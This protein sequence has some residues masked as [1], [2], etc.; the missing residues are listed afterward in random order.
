MKRRLLALLLVLAMVLAMAPV[1]VLAEETDTDGA[2]DS[3][4]S[5]TY[6]N[7]TARVDFCA[8][9]DVEGY[10]SQW[11]RRGVTELTVVAASY[12]YQQM[13]DSAY[14]KIPMEDVE[15]GR[16]TAQLQLQNTFDQSNWIRV[17]LLD[18][19]LQLVCRNDTM[20]QWEQ[21]L[22]GLDGEITWSLSSGTLALSGLFNLLSDMTPGYHEWDKYSS[23]IERVVTE[24][25]RNISDSAFQGYSSLYSV[26][27]GDGLET[28]GAYAFADD[29]AIVSVTLPASVK[30]VGDYAF[31]GISDWAW[32]EFAEGFDWDN[33]TIGPGNTAIEAWKPIPEPTEGTE[34]AESTDEA[35]LDAPEETV[36]ET[37][38]ETVPEAEET[39]PETLPAAEEP[40]EEADYSGYYIAPEGAELKDEAALE[41]MAAYYGADKNSSGVHTA[42]FTGLVPLQAYLF[43]ASRTPGSLEKEDLQYIGF[44]ASDDEGNVS[45]RYIPKENVSF[46]VQ[47][48]GPEALTLEVNQDYV[49]LHPGE[50]FTFTFASNYDV[51]VWG[52][53]ENESF[54]FR[55]NEDGSW[56]LTAGEDTELAECAT[57][58]L[59]FHANNGLQTVRTR[60]RV[61]LVPAKT[62]VAGVILGETKLTRNLYDSAATQI[63]ILLDRDYPVT[64]NGTN[65]I[66]AFSAEENV[67]EGRLIRSVRFSDAA[68]P[69]AKD[70]FQI[71]VQDDRTLLLDTA[72]NLDLTDAA[73]VKAV[74]GSYK[75]GF[76][77]TFADGTELDTGVLTLTVQKKLP[78][79]KAA[80]VTLNP[81]YNATQL[82][83]VTGGSVEGLTEVVTP[84]EGVEAEV[85]V[86]GDV[87]VCL[88]ETPAK[89][90]SKSLVVQAMVEGC[91][92][93]VKL[94]IPV[95]LDVK[96]PACKLQTTNWTITRNEN[97]SIW[98]PI[99][100]T[101]KNANPGDMDFGIPTVYDAKG[102]PSTAYTAFL[103]E[104]SRLNIGTFYGDIRPAGK[105]TLTIVVPVT[106]KDAEPD[107]LVTAP[108]TFKVTVTNQDLELKLAKSSVTLNAI[109][110]DNVEAIVGMN[111]TLG[112]EPV[113]L[114]GLSFRYGIGSSNEEFS[115]DLLSFFNVQIYSEGAVGLQLNLSYL[116]SEESG[117][118]GRMDEVLA[119]TYDFVIDVVGDES[120]ID[121]WAK[122]TVHLGQDPT[123]LTGLK[124]TGAIDQIDNESFVTLSATYRNS[125]GNRVPGI[126]VTN[127]KGEDCTQLFTWRYD[128][129]SDTIHLSVNP[130]ENTPEAGK[131][132]VTLTN[133]SLGVTTSKSA[134]F[135]VKASKPAVKV[136]GKVDSLQSDVYAILS[137]NYRQLTVDGVLIW[138]DVTLYTT[139]KTP[140]PVDPSLYQVFDDEAT[141]NLKISANP[142]GESLLPAGKYTAELDYRDGT[143]LSAPVTVTQTAA[144]FKLSKSSTTVHP[145]FSSDSAWIT[146]S[147]TNV[148]AF[149]GNSG[150]EYYQANGK[151]AWADQ[152]LVKVELDS[153]NGYVTVTPTGV[154][155]DKDTTVK[156]KLLPD[157]RIPAKCT[158]LTVKVLGGKNLTQ[159]LTLK[160]VNAL[161]P[162][163]AIPSTELQCTLKGFDNCY[164][165]G[166]VKLLVS[167]DRGKTY[168]EFPGSGDCLTTYA[169]GTYA[170]LSVSDTWEDGQRVPSLDP[171][172][173]YRVQVTYGS[174]DAPAAVGTLD[175]KVAFA[176][177]KFTVAQMPTL[178]K[179]DP[180]EPMDIHLNAGSLAQRI[181]RVTLKGN[182]DFTVSKSVV[183]PEDSVFGSQYDW[184][185]R[186]VGQNPAKLKTT[187][188]TLQI[189]LK[190]NTTDKPN[191]TAT[192]KVNVK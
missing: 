26:E 103:S 141:G 153:Y 138:P 34:P 55:R 56:T 79:L 145:R 19:D 168:Q 137:S 132:T 142:Y 45:V 14:V 78:T 188:L 37:T 41:E 87:A 65:S 40:Q 12:D 97:D 24:N 134:S 82:V 159:K 54:D 2:A 165:E 151:T 190:G 49:T 72:E 7:A 117:Y 184:V 5:S 154:E 71:S 176:S 66:A 16:F 99:Q 119:A 13:L 46:L 30:T 67:T 25:V 17:F 74:K 102:N 171:S 4:S 95:K 115:D 10:V 76:R 126:E 85:S 160:A 192:V 21:T 94:T 51:D 104:D 155:P 170:Y 22:S 140:A 157:T 58:Y 128:Y 6:V 50:S 112:G 144:A 38:V 3:D 189:F 57:T 106:A 35:V 191:A 31:D 148:S 130:A 143:V 47:L 91:S 150:V 77:L 68:D 114:D 167:Q 69:A 29:S 110:F 186:Y 133:K 181:D 83:T 161:D 39:V 135:T 175:L 118:K 173:K 81:Y 185:L 48:Y 73:V 89:A 163:N 52:D 93:P 187:T 60:V 180:F 61:D 174:E 27:L 1:G 36:P 146:A 53:I 90:A 100:W 32:V 28:V 136:T 9:V 23:R 70:L 96:A 59:E 80:A 149:A 43:I 129:N 121:N 8:E 75:L 111:V 98:I 169:Y 84:V 123:E 33:V 64:Q 183:V 86:E 124:A 131:Y 147:V 178:Y 122:L 162:S 172:L 15:D 62:I 152:D 108:L 44:T 42:S 177:N 139:G 125:W 113:D 158:W 120:E 92:V 63:P 101:D 116:E 88:T 182:T 20:A 166:S 127:S 179:Q 156:V 11:D 18:Q 109:D 107:T 164:M 105:E